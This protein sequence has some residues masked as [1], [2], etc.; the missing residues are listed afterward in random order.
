MPSI[1]Q[2]GLGGASKES[3]SLPPCLIPICLHIPRHHTPV[4]ITYAS[5]RGGSYALVLTKFSHP[6]RRDSVWMAMGVLSTF[7]LPGFWPLCKLDPQRRITLCSAFSGISGHSSLTVLVLS[8]PSLRNLLFGPVCCASC[9]PMPLSSYDSQ[10]CG[11]RYYHLRNP[12]NDDNQR[13]ANR[14][15]LPV[16]AEACQQPSYLR[17]LLCTG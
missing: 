11:P 6:S 15:S 5:T 12:Y 9:R 2:R 8:L 3:P 17:S 14:N 7:F 13:T 4:F 1:P 16:Q 10:H